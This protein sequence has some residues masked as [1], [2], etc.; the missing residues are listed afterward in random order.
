[1]WFDLLR[2]NT[3]VRERTQLATQKQHHDNQSRLR[4]F[5]VGTPVQGQTSWTPP[6][7]VLKQCGSMSYEV[8]LE[9]G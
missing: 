9:S 3:G 2:P 6:G 1:M 5:S 7:V 4:E 8:H